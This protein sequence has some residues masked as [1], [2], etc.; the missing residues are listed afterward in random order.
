MKFSF[1]ATTI[2]GFEDVASA[3]VKNLL[4]VETKPN[5]GRIFFEAG[6]DAVYKVNLGGR[7][8]H[9]VFLILTQTKF[10]KLED[11]YKETKN[12][13]YKWI[14]SPNQTFAVR[15][16]R[17]GKH[18][19]TSIDAAAKIGQAV[20]D[21]YQSS[22]NIRLKVNLKNP[23]LEFYGFIKNE[24]FILSLNMT[25]ESLHKRGYRVYQHPAALKPSLAC[26]LI[27]FCEW[28]YHQPFLDP[29]CGGGTIPIEAALM[30]KNKPLNSFKR[31]FAFKKLKIHDQNLY[32]EIK[33]FFSQ[34][35]SVKPKIYG[36]EVSPK[37]FQGAQANVFSAGVVED[38]NLLL[39]DARKL[40]KY[41]DKDFKPEVVVVNLPYGIRS[42][43]KSFLEKL[44]TDF[45]VSLKNVTDKAILAALT[46]AK[47]EF[48][49]ALENVGVSLMEEKEVMH[50]NLK[51]TAFKC[52]V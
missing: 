25:G 30:A 52:K 16:E 6:F 19:F 36:V 18:S 17:H 42:S 40:Q 14:I 5:H 23:D 9:K 33:N 43:R 1:M 38:V 29:M 13:D 24:N 11:L 39:G 46:S 32:E 22:T 41:L 31:E 49:K 37:H 4:N 8:I 20:I 7:C 44:Y 10:K 35:L 50:G 26:C 34:K 51:V 45:L 12:I 27:R 3:E 21:S 28:T 47:N 48:K 2:T 15:V